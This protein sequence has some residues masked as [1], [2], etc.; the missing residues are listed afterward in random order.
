MTN[1]SARDKVSLSIAANRRDREPQEPCASQ[2]TV[3]EGTC[4]GLLAEV[5]VLEGGG[6]FAAPGDPAARGE[7]AWTNRDTAEYSPRW[8]VKNSCRS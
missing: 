1:K 7:N 8:A 5:G 6:E 4:R 2:Q 3:F